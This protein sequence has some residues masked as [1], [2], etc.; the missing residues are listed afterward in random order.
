MLPFVWFFF[1]MCALS[2]FIEY[3]THSEITEFYKSKNII[4]FFY[5]KNGMHF[6]QKEQKFHNFRNKSQLSEIIGQRI[7][8]L[9][10]DLFTSRWNF[11]WNLENISDRFNF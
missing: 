6:G 3:Y 1:W 2:W 8:V 5:S 10:F 9:Y 11:I 7:F 4:T